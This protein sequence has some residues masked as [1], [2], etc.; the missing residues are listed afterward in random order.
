MLFSAAT[1]D[2]ATNVAIIIYTKLH[3]FKEWENQLFVTVWANTLWRTKLSCTASVRYNVD[4]RSHPI[5][6]A[7]HG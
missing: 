1:A 4:W 3:L 7:A 5:Q 6:S 2:A